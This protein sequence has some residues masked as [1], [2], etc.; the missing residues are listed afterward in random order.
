MATPTE[1]KQLSDW[2]VVVYRE[3]ASVSGSWGLG[4]GQ[5]VNITTN[6]CKWFGRLGWEGIYYLLTEMSYKF[7]LITRGVN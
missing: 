4:V 5:T 6:K 2:S 1:E 3:V 7:I